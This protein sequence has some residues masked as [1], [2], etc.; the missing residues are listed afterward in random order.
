M[1]E[2]NLFLKAEI[3]FF[4]L[5]DY[6]KKT[7]LHTATAMFYLCFKFDSIQFRGATTKNRRDNT[8]VIYGKASISTL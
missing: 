3:K 4:D 2:L 5:Y 1:H 6:V 7:L 8:V